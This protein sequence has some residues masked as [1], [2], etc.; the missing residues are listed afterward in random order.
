MN[1]R[2]TRGHALLLTVLLGLAAAGCNKGG[3][4]DAA[5]G[6]GS[7]SSGTGSAGTG[8]SGSGSAGGSG[9]ASGSSGS[10]GS[11]T[12]GAT[13]TSGASGTGAATAAG[14]AIDDS[15]ITTKLKTALLADTTLKGSDIS[16]ETRNGEVVLTGSVASSSQKDHAAKIAQ[17]LSGVKGVNNKLSVKK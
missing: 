13:G 2:S 3:G 9:S 5:G 17:A 11:D 6:A 15:V 4:E 7:S 10:A 16:V 14:T 12:S 8:S 1:F